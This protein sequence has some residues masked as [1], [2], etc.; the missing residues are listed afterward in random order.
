[1]RLLHC[2]IFAL[3]PVLAM[4]QAHPCLLEP[5]DL[6]KRYAAGD[7]AYAAM[8][9]FCDKNLDQLIRGGYVAWDQRNA[10]ENYATAYLVETA[11]GN[12]AL[13]DAYGKKGVA[14][15]K[16]LARNHSYGSVPEAAFLGRGDGTTREFTLPFLPLAGKPCSVHLQEIKITPLT[17][18]AG[19]FSKLG[20]Y[21]K[22]YKI[23]NTSDGPADYAAGEYVFTYR[24]GPAG[25]GGIRWLTGHHPAAGATYYVTWT[26]DAEAKIAPVDSYTIVGTKMT[27]TTAPTAMQVVLAR[28]IGTDYE[29]TVNGLGGLAAVQPDGPGYPMRT[30][31]VGLAY[32]YD[33]LY[34]YAGFTPELKKDFAAILD[35]QCGWYA[36][37]GYEHESKSGM[38]NYYVEGWLAGS[39]YT[40]FAI[41]KENPERAAH[42]KEVAHGLLRT[43]AN[44]GNAKLPGG[45]GP[46]GQYTNGTIDHLLRSMCVWRDNGG[47]D[48]IVSSK[49]IGSTIPAV[50]HGTKPDRTTFYD[51]G[52]WSNLPATPLFP[53]I[54]SIIRYLPE[55]ADNAFARQLLTDANQPVP[56][57]PLRDYKSVYE[58][59]YFCDVSGPVYMRSDWT[60]SAVWA[61]LS[62][63]EDFID[64]QHRDAG[65]VTIHRGGD[66]LLKD[67]GGYGD[68]ASQ[69]HNVLLFDDR[70]CGN[71]IVYPPNQG[72]WGGSRV[73]IAN[74][75]ARPD[76][77]YAQADATWAYV[78]NDG[79]RNSVKSALRTLLY[80]RPD[81]LVVHDQARVFNPNVIK[82]TNWNFGAALTREGNVFSATLGQSRISM[83]SIVPA[84]PA[85]KIAP[86][87]KNGAIQ[88]QVSCKGNNDDTF[89]HVFQATDR[90]AKGMVAVDYLASAAGTSQGVQ[91]KGNPHWVAMFAKAD[92]LDTVD[93]QPALIG[94][95]QH[96]IGDLK[97]NTPHHVVVTADK[98]V[99]DTTLTANAQGVLA[100]TFTNTAPAH[101]IITRRKE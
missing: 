43:S 24:D 1:M 77:V 26:T 57:G 95:Q 12:A 92:T 13:A 22:V 55:Q 8:K 65:Q 75:Y 39:M 85:P 32:A 81:V 29:Q 79:V 25:Q 51:G 16:V 38:G 33:L 40:A 86:Y 31:N 6:V 69:F 14:L 27:F 66:Y 74:Y 36:R 10:L 60:G 47:E 17:Y 30:Y 34:N 80:I 68:S 9:A 87:G 46:Q 56:A 21:G 42:W 70:G 82:L 97:P 18:E 71:L 88:Y 44:S 63:G 96:V 94:P 101:V 54:N 48:L 78:H 2:V 58:P 49:W 62:A 11:R 37:Y 61:S 3:C 53:A 99:L 76:A 64:H 90:G 15:M 5:A 50:I 7:P 89:L 93:Y 35:A 45:Y 20:P 52:D 73:K 84:N 19:G 83:K 23:S 67:A 59:H 100:F 91:I 72:V 98:V 41:A 28:Y 4:A